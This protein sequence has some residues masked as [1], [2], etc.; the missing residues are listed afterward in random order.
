MRKSRNV[1]HYGRKIGRI[2]D[3][4]SG[5]RAQVEEKRK[6]EEMIV[7]EK[8]SKIRLTGNLPVTCFC[9]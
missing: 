1:K 2:D 6:H 3:I 9:F 7:K 8:A 5:A 4:V